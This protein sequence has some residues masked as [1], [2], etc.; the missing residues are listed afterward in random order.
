MLLGSVRESGWEGK[1]RK[2]KGGG[3]TRRGGREG[4]GEQREEGEGWREDEERER[5][6][7]KGGW[8]GLTYVVER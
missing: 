6:G 5:A 1:G 8:G 3:R 2:E 4:E 7:K